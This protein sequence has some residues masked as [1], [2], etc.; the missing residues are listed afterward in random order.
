M[1]ATPPTNQQ[2]EIMKV[3]DL[4]P[5][6]AGKKIA[7][8][9]Q[10]NREARGTLETLTFTWETDGEVWAQPQ[11]RVKSAI[12]GISGWT[13]EVEGHAEVELAEQNSPALPTVYVK[14]NGCSVG[15]NED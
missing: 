6:D 10:L 4:K 1:T 7:V 5:S 12:L 11:H 13:I 15:D 9:D 8:T 14:F 2:G 3:T